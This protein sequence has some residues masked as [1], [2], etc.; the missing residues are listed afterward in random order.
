MKKKAIKKRAIKKRALSKDDM[1]AL[2]DLLK[3][4]PKLIHALIFDP[5]VVKRLL[6]RKAARRQAP[7]VNRRAKAILREQ[8]PPFCLKG[9]RL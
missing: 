3:A 7:E 9:T 8:H 4:H 2:L 5:T 1:G 6:K